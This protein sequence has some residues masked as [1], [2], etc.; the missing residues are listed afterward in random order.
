MNKGFDIAAKAYDA[1]FT[2][3]P[4]GQSQRYF[5]HR[6]LH[7]FLANKK[8]LRI[9]EINC[10]TGEDAI[11]LGKLGHNVIATDLSKQMITVA[12]KKNTLPNVQF[13]KMAIQDL[14]KDSIG[15]NFD[16]IFSN[17]G[18]INCLDIEEIQQSF[19]TFHQLLRPNGHTILVVMPKYCV[20]ENV[21]FKLKKDSRYKRRETNNRVMAPVD[22]VKIPTWYYNPKKLQALSP[23]WKI[24]RCGPIGLFVPPSYLNPF[25]KKRKLLLKALHKTDFLFQGKQTFAPYADHFLIDFKKQ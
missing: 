3:S 14:N 6:Y 22:G 2:N 23:N 9:L 11:W 16:L 21:Y 19:K 4:I 18:G 13:L 5:V 10:G 25:F 17:F 24:N 8:K 15:S 12:T 20:W 7:V 1:S